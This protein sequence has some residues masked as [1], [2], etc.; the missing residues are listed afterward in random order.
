LS[1]ATGFDF[2][3]RISQVFIVLALTAWAIAFTGLIR[4]I[5]RQ[6][7][8]ARLERQAKPRNC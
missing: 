6:L 4:C 7:S 5:W 1:R 2:L 8:A 3:A